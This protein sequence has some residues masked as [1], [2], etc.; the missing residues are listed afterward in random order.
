MGELFYS[1]GPKH[2]KDCF[3]NVWV[4]FRLSIQDVNKQSAN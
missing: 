4:P 1:P 3:L 2:L